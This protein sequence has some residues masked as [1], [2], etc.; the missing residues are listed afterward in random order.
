MYLMP[1]GSLWFESQPRAQRSLESN[2]LHFDAVFPFA[3]EALW[4]PE[5][6]LDIDSVFQTLLSIQ[7]ETIAGLVPLQLEFRSPF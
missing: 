3:D 1:A 6:A 5:V 7:P 2:L 4:L